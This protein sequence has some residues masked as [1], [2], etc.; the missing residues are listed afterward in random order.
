MQEDHGV[1][2]DPLAAEL[3]RAARALA[4][5][6]ARAAA[7]RSEVVDR[8]TVH[9]LL[10]LVAGGPQRTTA[11]AHAVLAAPSTVSRQVVRDAHARHT[12][13]VTT[14]VAGWPEQDR[15]TLTRL[16]ARGTDGLEQR[17]PQVLALAEPSRQHIHPEEDT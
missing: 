6:S 16:L 12:A 14:V 15:T 7:L 4:R 10:R 8:T 17:R 9:L 2:L 11:L 1:V 3:V 13:A 5:T